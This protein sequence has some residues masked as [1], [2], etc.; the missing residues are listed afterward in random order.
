MKAV[1]PGAARFL[2]WRASLTDEQ[3]VD[4]GAMTDDEW[5]AYV[6]GTLGL[7]VSL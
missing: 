1:G 3:C 4:W 2:L 6:R 7:K 5:E